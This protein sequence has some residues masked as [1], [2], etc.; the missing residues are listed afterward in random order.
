[1]TDTSQHSPLGGSGAARWMRCPGSVA[2]SYGVEDEESEYATAGL[3][4]HA[5]AEWC[6]RSGRDAW[7]LVRDD[8]VVDREMADAV[9]VYLNAACASC[10][11]RTLKGDKWA[12]QWGKTK[13]F[14]E[15]AHGSEGLSWVELE[16]HCP[17]IHE[18]CW[19]KADF[20]YWSK[21]KRELHVW[22]YKH[23]AGIVV[24]VERNP[25]LMYYGCGVLESLDLW[26]EVDKV[27]LHIA[28]PRGFHYDG[29][30]RSWAVSTH[31]LWTWKDD[32]LV[33]AMDRAL[34]SRETA[35]GEHCR[36]CPARSRACP[37]VLEDFDE[38]E[39][40][41]SAMKLDEKDS[42]GELTNAQAGRLLDLYDVAKIAAKAAGK[43][44]FA[45]LEAGKKVPGRKLARARANRKWK[46]EAE[47]ALL[48][49]FGGD[50]WEPG[51]LK[52]PAKVEEMPEGEKMTAR[53]AYKPD[54]GLTV[55]REDDS[56]PAVGKDTKAL[57]KDQTK[58]GKKK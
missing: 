52:S 2:L 27:M 14:A 43:T 32:V 1:M 26:N 8:S 4:A 24:E 45:R 22:D 9:Q 28:Q 58:K 50:A 34:A 12:A 15:F 49:K 13:L 7:E 20:T 30:I 25:Q 46:D 31:D 29:P 21:L 53:W 47:P 16:F 57:F 36:F 33:P 3:Q 17:T 5:L 6:L 23:G 56:R 19:G 44:V 48:K 11:S 10:P 42:A 37:Q 35:S 18:Y 38:M 55:V 40:L 54:A 41:M 39:A 51:K